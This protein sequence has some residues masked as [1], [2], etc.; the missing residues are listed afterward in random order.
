LPFAALR[1]ETNSLGRMSALGRIPTSN[2]LFHIVRRIAARNRYFQP[3][4][5][6]RPGADIRGPY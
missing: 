3:T 4:D 2:V 1:R 5:G 6:S